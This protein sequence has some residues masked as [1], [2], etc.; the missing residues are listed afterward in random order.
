MTEISV[1]GDCYS[2]VPVRKSDTGQIQVDDKLLGLHNENV[3][4]ARQYRQDIMNTFLG[5]IRGR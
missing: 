3:K 2:V 1:D 4:E 5:L